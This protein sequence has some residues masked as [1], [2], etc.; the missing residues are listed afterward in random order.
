MELMRMENVSQGYHTASALLPNT[1]FLS[2]TARHLLNYQAHNAPALAEFPRYSRLKIMTSIEKNILSLGHRG[3]LI[4]ILHAR[5][6]F[7]SL[8]EVGLR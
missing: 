7:I 1:R 4:G 8:R 5:K 3:L 2:L 6:G